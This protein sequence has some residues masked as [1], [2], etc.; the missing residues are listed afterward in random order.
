MD[1]VFD[2]FS[3]QDAE[4]VKE[5]EKTTNHDVKAVEYFLKERFDANAALASEK[6][7][8]HF[9]CTSE[10]INNLAYALMLH[11]SFQDV[12]LPAL[13]DLEGKLC[14]LADELAEVPML[15]RTHGQSATPS[16]MG[17]EIANFAYRLRA[18]IEN[19]EKIQ[20][21]GKFNGATGNLNAHQVAFPDKDWIEISRQFVEE[22]GI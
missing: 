22:L 4:R 14:E 11:H 13:R 16:T 15:C 17:K 5:I 9:S 20:P 19:L 6:E 10:D 7:Y 1:Q 18:Q 21:K 8:L 2:N 3:L 12:I